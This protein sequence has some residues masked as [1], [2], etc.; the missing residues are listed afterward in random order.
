MLDFLNFITVWFLVAT[1][2]VLL[3]LAGANG[4]ELASGYWRQWRTLPGSRIAELEREC[5]D[6]DRQL[7]DMSRLPKSHGSY[8]NELGLAQVDHFRQELIRRI[9]QERLMAHAP[10]L[11]NEQELALQHPSYRDAQKVVN[12]FLLELQREGEANGLEGT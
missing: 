12:R 4:F 7:A 10:S 1:I 2:L 6:L 3:I 5:A 8:P 11:R 9:E